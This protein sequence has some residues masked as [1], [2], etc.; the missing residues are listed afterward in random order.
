MKRVAVVLGIVAGLALGPTQASA[1]DS[2]DGAGA[3]KQRQASHHRRKPQVR[4]Y[5][6]RRG[7]YS[8]TQADIIN[9]YGDSGHHVAPLQHRDPKLQKQPQ[10]FDSGFFYDSGILLGGG[11][12]PYMN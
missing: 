3:H 5:V 7:G 9:T 2:S 6:A 1:D 4:G 8:Y 12:S 11:H 10:P